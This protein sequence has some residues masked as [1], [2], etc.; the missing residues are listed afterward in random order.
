[1]KIT[2]E[3]LEFR[4]QR[5][6][7]NFYNYT[8]TPN[9]LSREETAYYWLIKSLKT[10]KQEGGDVYD[11]KDSFLIPLASKQKL[12]EEQ[13]DFIFDIV[14]VINDNCPEYRSLDFKG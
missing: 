8:Y 10:F 5:E 7:N 1:M 2:R 13:E 3:E 14:D 11:F 9:E 6:V 12:K 4:V